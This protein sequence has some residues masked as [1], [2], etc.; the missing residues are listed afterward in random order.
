ML[1]QGIQRMN[2]LFALETTITIPGDFSLHAGDPVYVDAPELKDESTSM[3]KNK[4]SS[5]AL[6][7]STSWNKINTI[8]GKK[9]KNDGK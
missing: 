3:D 8:K 2:Q 7:W 6:F 4:Q 5:K 9:P 1:N